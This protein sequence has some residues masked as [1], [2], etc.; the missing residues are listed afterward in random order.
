MVD[1]LEAA[2]LLVCG[3]I[4][5]G[6]HHHYEIFA[7]LGVF[8]DRTHLVIGECVAAAA[9]TH[10]FARSGDSLRKLFNILFR[11]IQNMKSQTLCGFAAHSRQSRQMFYQ[12]VDLITVIFH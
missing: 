4:P 11:H 8:T 2:G 12:L 3:Q 1:S 5:R 9:Q 6:L 10:I 7:A